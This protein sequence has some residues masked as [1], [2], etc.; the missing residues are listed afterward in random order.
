MNTAII[1]AAGNSQRFGGEIPKQFLKINGKAIIDYSIDIFN[2]SKYIDKII[3]VVAKQFISNI[4]LRYPNLDVIEGGNTRKDS[5]YLG[6]CQCPDKTK[7]V[8]I[9]DA[10]RMFI[11]DDI[12]KNC[13]NALS[14][15][16]AVTMA[17]K[18]TDTI[19]KYKNKNIIS[20][21][22]REE[23]IALQTPQ[24]FDYKKLFN[25]HKNF[26]GLATDD[27]RI[28]LKNGYKCSFI[29]TNKINLK[30]TTYNDYLIASSIIN[31]NKNESN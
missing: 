19:A 13:I 12:I 5:T 9:H 20:M 14:K 2:N 27:I 18:I 8:L 17:S 26:Q 22:D 3:I 16:D 4:K 24:G 10:A 11:S 29:F 6:L 23:L 1:L 15:N 30:I 21:V 31:N 7:F 25:S 28:M